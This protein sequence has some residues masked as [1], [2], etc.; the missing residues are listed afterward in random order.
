MLEWKEKTR[1]HKSK[2][3]EILG[4]KTIIV[5]IKK[6]DG[7]NMT[8][9]IAEGWTSDLGDWDEEIYQTEERVTQFRY[10]RAKI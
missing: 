4:I 5:K 2:Q 8:E 9:E 6:K 3:G 7:K 10:V 1:K